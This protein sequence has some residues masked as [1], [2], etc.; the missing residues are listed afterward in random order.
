MLDLACQVVM[1][2][3]SCQVPNAHVHISTIY[4]LGPNHYHNIG[5]QNDRLQILIHMKTTLKIQYLFNNL[6]HIFFIFN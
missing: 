1:S 2:N 6:A 4:Y 5:S 3:N